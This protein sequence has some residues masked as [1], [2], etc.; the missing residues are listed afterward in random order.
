MA[1]LRLAMAQVNPVVGDLVG[2]ARMIR[3]RVGEA[4]L[5]GAHLVAFPEMVLTGYPVEDLA[6]RASF[7]EASR[8]ALTQLAQDLVADGHGDLPVV[9]GYLDRAD[10]AS[11]DGRGG[12]GTRTLPQ[13]CAAVLSEGRVV[14]RYAKHHL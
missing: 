10:G 13:N 5:A 8:R 14:G 7:V 9:V 3:D 12:D 2:N 4:A 11:P 1:Q 6:L